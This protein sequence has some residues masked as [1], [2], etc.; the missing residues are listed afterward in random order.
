MVLEFWRLMAK[1]SAFSRNRL[2][3][4]F[5]LLFIVTKTW[6]S[7]FWGP[8]P[9]QASK[10]MLAIDSPPPQTPLPLEFWRFTA[11]KWTFLWYSVSLCEND[12]KIIFFHFSGR[13]TAPNAKIDVANVFA[14][15]KN[16]PD[17]WI[18][19][20]GLQKNNLAINM[21][22]YAIFLNIFKRSKT[23]FFAPLRK[24]CWHFSL[25][26]RPCSIEWRYFQIFMKSPVRDPLAEPTNR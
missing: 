20:N 4:Q 21:H 26:N 8:G 1:K 12:K 7:K 19:I 16:P 11:K 10:I 2:F 22:I 13:R 17:D 3:S 25:P 6:H 24:I 9:I 15:H 23:H 5:S 14:D 18:E